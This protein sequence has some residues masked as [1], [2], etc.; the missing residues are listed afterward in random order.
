MSSTK[1]L[2][3]NKPDRLTIE[4]TNVCNAN[5]CFCAKK[6]MT[7]KTGVMDYDLYTNIIDQAVDWG[8]KSIRFTPLIGDPLC[9]PRIIERIKYAVSK[10][11]FDRIYF[12]TNLIGLKDPEVLL[13]SGMDNLV[14]STC[15]QGREEYKRVY[16][17][18][19]YDIVVSNLR[20]LFK[21]NIRQGNP[22]K[23]QITLKHSKKG[24]DEYLGFLKELGVKKKDYEV[25]QGYDNW[26]GNIQEN[27]LPEGCSFRKK[28]ADMRVPC[29][30]SFTSLCVSWDG[31]VPTCSI[32]DYD[33]H[34]SVGDVTKQPM[35]DI[36]GKQIKEAKTKWFQTGQPP[37]Y[38]RNCICYEPVDK[39]RFIIREEMKKN[40]LLLLNKAIRKVKRGR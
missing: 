11:H 8:I 31:L 34:L 16:G 27:D 4:T 2:E 19:K 28:A 22:V 29:S 6:H 17:V 12:F 9:D 26:G 39:S 21:E 20:S 5:C 1:L 15:L 3:R 36:W 18:D 37:E 38:C 13:S 14:I 40:P 25:I 7:R 30:Q 33:L 32:R 23:I 24:G 10:D 35:K